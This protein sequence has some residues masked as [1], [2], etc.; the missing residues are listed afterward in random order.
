MSVSAQPKKF[1][2]ERRRDLL[3]HVRTRGSATIAELASLVGASPVTIHRDLELLTS[4]GQLVRVHG[5]ALAVDLSD[6]P[7]ASRERG[8]RVSQK[9]AIAQ[10]AVAMVDDKV[11][12]V[13]LEGSTTVARLAPLLRNLEDKVILTNSPEIAMEV[14][15]G[16]AEV[17]LIGGFLR[18]RTLSTVGSSAIQMLSS[19]SIDLAFVG[20]SALD[21]D[22]LSSMNSV[23]ADTKSAIIRAAARSVALGDGSKLGRRALVPVAPLASLEALI[24]DAGA[25]ASELSALRN[26]GLDIIVAN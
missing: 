18:R 26:R 17:L 25:A 7:P 12:S 1:A 5:G 14:V 19:V 24:T 9:Q 4:Q 20:V 21:A 13:F 22:G 16:E 3:Q 11:S 6:D 2:W 8:E 10:A 23:E 15:Q